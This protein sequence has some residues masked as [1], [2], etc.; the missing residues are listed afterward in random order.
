LTFAEPGHVAVSQVFD[1]VGEA[2]ASGQATS[3]RLLCLEG[4]KRCVDLVALRA[5]EGHL[6]ALDQKLVCA[7]QSSEHV[8]FFILR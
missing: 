6:F 1:L 4:Y 5:V 7:V 2:T 3:V 8:E